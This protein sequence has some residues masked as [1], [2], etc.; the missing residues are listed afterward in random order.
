MEGVRVHSWTEL[1]QQTAADDVSFNSRL[2]R[3]RSPFA[4][5]GISADWPLTIG[6]QRLKHDIPTL[7]H[8][9][10]AATPNSCARS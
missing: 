9:E 1:L 7:R 6:I 8:I 5:R 2:Q 3:F 4:F 10:K